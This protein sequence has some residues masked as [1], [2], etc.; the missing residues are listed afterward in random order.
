MVNYIPIHYNFIVI[1]MNIEGIE[2]SAPGLKVP[3]FI[4]FYLNECICLFGTIVFILLIM[5]LFIFPRPFSKLLLR[6][7]NVLKLI[8]F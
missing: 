6:K 4:Y 5:G 2:P 7:L 1:T 8:L 3:C